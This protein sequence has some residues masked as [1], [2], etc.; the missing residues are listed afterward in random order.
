M[1]ILGSLHT[2]VSG[3]KASGTNM[4]IIGDNI[5]NAGTTAFKAS[6]GEFQ[7][8]VATN[9]KGILGGNQIGSGVKL[10]A[11]TP[12]FQQGN[13]T[14]SERDADMAVRGDGFF[15]VKSAVAGNE[16]SYTRDGSFR[17]DE[18]GRLQTA[19]HQLVQG[20]KIDPESGKPGAELA[21]VAFN[22]NT[23]PAKGTAT[24]KIDSNLDARAVVN[25]QAYNVLE[26]DK[27]ADYSTSVR[28]HD[29]TGTSRTVNMHF[30]KTTENEWTWHASADGSSL[31]GGKE[32]ISQEIASGKLSFTTDGKLNND[33][34]SNSNI[35]F[36]GAQPNQK[37]DFNFGD[38]ILS[39]KGTGL[40][41]TTAY[42]AKSQVYRQ[43]QD[44]YAA[45]TLTNF[46]V[47]ESGTIS[48]SYSNGITRPL[49]VMA[50]ARFE[51]PEGLFKVGSNRF[52]E[53]VMSGQPLVGN[54]QESGRG[55]ILAKT[56]ENSN[57]DL[58]HEFVGMIQT[59]RN[60]QA[61]AKTI[62]TSDELLQEVINL[63][64]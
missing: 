47:E 50:L 3:L 59:Q 54:P 24:V 6:R 14:P 46:S 32:G 22:S 5:A 2:G 17:F 4:G 23:I 38:A 31:A 19:D 52:K 57:V 49:A 37:V 42:G 20:Y 15:V 43:V 25:T 36:K 11:V 63:K 51:N 56:L 13:L 45:G 61:N 44:G 29:T 30:Y 33:V 9:L 60:F 18:K 21:D 64:R 16:V 8:V 58:A 53:A 55:A 7:D 12:I 10:N 62:T 26:A 27:T 40:I 41:G 1:S 34:L 39:R 35:N 28:V 48:G